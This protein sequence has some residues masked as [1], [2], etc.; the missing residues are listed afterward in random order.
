MRAFVAL[1]I[2][3]CIIS[4][5]HILEIYLC[6]HNIVV[7]LCFQHYPCNTLLTQ[8]N[9]ATNPAAN[10]KSFPIRDPMKHLNS[11]KYERMYTIRSFRQPRLFVLP[12]VD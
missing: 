12:L 9:P 6:K 1:L 11:L 2:S 8:S 4:L 3:L 10:C 5:P 7:T